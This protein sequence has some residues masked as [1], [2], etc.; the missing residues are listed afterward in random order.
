M[1]GIAIGALGDVGIFFVREEP[2]RV[3]VD[4]SLTT[5]SLSFSGDNHLISR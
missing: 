3:K 4:V 1:I 2:Y 5:F